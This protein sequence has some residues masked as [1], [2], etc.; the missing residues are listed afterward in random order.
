VSQ[1][2]FKLISL[3]LRILETPRLSRLN[4]FWPEKID[5]K[6]VWLRFLPV[7]TH[8]FLLH[9]SI[10]IRI[11][12][13]CKGFKL[14][15]LSLKILETPG[16]SR[17]NSVWHKKIYHKVVWSRFLPVGTSARFLHRTIVIWIFV[18]WKGFKLISLVLRILVT[19][20]LSQL[21]FVWPKKIDHKFVWLRCLPVGTHARFLHQTIVIRIFVSRKGFKL[22]SLALRI[23]GTPGLSW[24]N[25]FCAR[26]LMI[27]SYG[28][29]FFQLGL[30]LAFCIRR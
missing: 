12:V 19:L 16:F 8:A 13:S 17:L 2:G 23:L 10:V 3:A 24:L 7:R 6:F 25:L 18:S 15:S 21:N 20:G 30:T 5:H 9:R 22:I 29:G 27:M 4:S 11:F 28:H 26:K 14:I 1:K